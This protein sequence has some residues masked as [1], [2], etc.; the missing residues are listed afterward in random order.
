MKRK[1][2]KSAAAALVVLM[3]FSGLPFSSYAAQ[4]NSAVP[5]SV[6]ESVA[7][8]VITTE[9]DELPVQKES[10]TATSSTQATTPQK[11]DYPKITGF[12]NTADGTKI[13]WSK[14][15][16]AAKYRLFIYNGTMWK[17]VGDS[18][19]T[20]YT[21]TKLKNGTTYLYTVRAMD[22]NNNFISGYYTQGYSNIFYVPPTVRALENVYGGV[23][24][25]WNKYYSVDNYRIYRKTKN[26]SWHYIGDAKGSSYTDKSASSGTNYTYTI[27]CLDKNGNLISSYNQ[28]K[29]ITYVKAPTISKIENTATGSKISWSKCSGAS[30]YRVF[31][32]DSNKKWK[33]L[34]TT[35]STSFTHDKLKTGTTYTYTVR[36]LD[37]KGNFISGYNKTGTSN[38]FLTT[39]KISS[40]KNIY[41]GVEVKW[42]K[43]SGAA[44]YRIYRK[45][46]SSGWSYI[47]DSDST[48]YVDKKASSGTNYT[49]TVR[50]L[51]KNGKLI[52]TYNQGKSIRYVKA[53]TI[54][55]IENTATGSKISWSKCSG[56]SKYRVFY[57]D[58]NKKWKGLGTTSSTSFTHDKLKTGTT[59]TYTVRCLDSKG[60]FISGFNGSGKSN[61]FLAPPTI[62]S[63]SKADNGN[64]IEWKSVKG[65]AGYRLYRKTVGS[66]WSVLADIAS[67]NSYIDT[68]AKKGNVYSYTLRCIDKNGNLISSYVSNTKYYYNGSLANGTIKVGSNKF[69]FDNGLLRSGLQTINGN[70]YYYNSS[71]VLQKNGI[72]G[73]DRDGWYYA[74]KNGKI[75]FTYSNA[76]TQNGKDWIVMGGKAT[77]VSTK[78]DRTLFRALKIVAK[79]TDKSMSKSQKLKVCF[80]YVK[81]AYTELNPRIPHYNG[82]DWPI[83]YANDM[84]VDGAGNCFSYAA[85][86]AYMAKAIGYKEVYCCHSGGHGWAEV[87]GLIYD[88]EWSRH[89][90]KDYY[91]LDYN[92]TKDPNYKAAIAPGYSWMHVKI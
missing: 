28:G 30:K 10:T 39:P 92:T 3:A 8:D 55:K 36:C 50:C 19:T 91:A 31:Y 33:G 35:S 88:P 81:G 23:S 38:V 69:Y 59:Y 7:A 89:H 70:K 80:N 77:K 51:D 13:S 48:T 49:Y 27:R 82:N 44:G 25:S 72:V 20:S 58:S 12:A 46:K 14:Y 11:A 2:L 67:G 62:S 41:G 87:D 66:S 9:D 78:S 60:N 74:D 56:A 86:F 52:S 79:I 6:V 4:I 26:S 61:L 22:K 1:F 42:G 83:I 47:G 68:S 16:G 15:A 75:D 64:L 37:S 34:G 63:V 17:R 71:G 54:S 57:L 53:P 29:S 24:V 40:L 45:T 21:H 5:E 32:L 73:S 85:A 90:S 43:L 65:V 18:T 76:V 84:F